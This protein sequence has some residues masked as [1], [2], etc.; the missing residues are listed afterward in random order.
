LYINLFLLSIPIL[1]LYSTIGKRKISKFI[2]KIIKP[3]VTNDNLKLAYQKIA[4]DKQRE[5]EA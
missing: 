2:E 4:K 5:I 3:Y 1:D